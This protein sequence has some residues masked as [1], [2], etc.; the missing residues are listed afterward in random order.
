MPIAIVEGRPA[1]FELDMEPTAGGWQTDGKLRIQGDESLNGTEWRV[2]LNGV[3]LESIGDVSEPYENPYLPFG[4]PDEYRAWVVP[5]NILKE[6]VNTAEVALVDGNRSVL[7][8]LGL[9]IK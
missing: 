5:V 8:W 3:E 2:T 4:N 1:I 6:G 7:V 9:A